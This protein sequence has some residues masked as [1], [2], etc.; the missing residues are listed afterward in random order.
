MQLAADTTGSSTLG[1]QLN[2]A[3][4]TNVNPNTIG[5]QFIEILPWVGIMV[6]VAFLLYEGKKLIKGAGKGKVR[7]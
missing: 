4:E 5:S 6:V 3:L 1:S 7:L 2:T